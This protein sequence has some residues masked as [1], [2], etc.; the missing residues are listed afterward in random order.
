M[1]DSDSNF[2]NGAS[3][4]TRE[5]GKQRPT[6]TLTEFVDARQHNNC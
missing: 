1:G 3:A 6:T 5:V 4:K 2:I